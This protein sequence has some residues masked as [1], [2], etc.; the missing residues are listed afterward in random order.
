[1]LEHFSPPDR[2]GEQEVQFH[3]VVIAVDMKRCL[4]NQRMHDWCKMLSWHFYLPRSVLPCR[5]G[6]ASSKVKR[7]FGK[8]M[9]LSDVA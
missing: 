6:G 3:A 1:M 7:F 5:K 9:K 4:D 2:D 8:T